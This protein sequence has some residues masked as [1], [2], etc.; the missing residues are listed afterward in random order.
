M[1]AVFT[2]VLGMLYPLAITVVGQAIF[3]SQAHGSLVTVDGETVGSSLLGQSFTDDPM[4]FQSRPSAAGDGYD[5]HG[6][7]GSNAG[8]LNADLATAIEE[9]RASVAAFNGVD[10]AAVPD[11]AL[12]AS[13]SGLDPDISPAYARLQVARVAAAR[14]LDEADVENLVASTLRGGE[15]GY[16]GEPRVNVLELNVA[17]DA[18]GS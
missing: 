5:G 13:A 4:Y 1:L 18:L 14:G 3:P 11:D 10:P 17:L 8:P 16:L 7:S 12:T 15:L 6:S 2:V 9:R